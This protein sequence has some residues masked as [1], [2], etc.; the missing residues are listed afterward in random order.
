MGW[1]ADKRIQHLPGY[2]ADDHDPLEVAGVTSSFKA[3]ARQLILDVVNNKIKL[4]PPTRKGFLLHF[5]AVLYHMEYY[6]LT[7]LPEENRS[8]PQENRIPTEDAADANFTKL[9]SDYGMDQQTRLTKEQVKAMAD[10]FSFRLNMKVKSSGSTDKS[11]LK[12]RL[13][14]IDIDWWGDDGKEHLQ[15]KSGKNLAKE[16][17]EN[18]KKKTKSR[19]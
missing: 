14:E 18:K 9:W 17:E 19:N 5:P 8:C 16:E 2:P 15:W 10:A 11:I 3:G 7:Y 13:R 1:H 12:Q 6:D 4:S